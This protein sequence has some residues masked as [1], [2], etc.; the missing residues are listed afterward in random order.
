[1]VRLMAPVAL[2]VTEPTVDTVGID[3]LGR[4]TELD[5]IGSVAS[6]LAQLN[7]SDAGGIY[8][9]LTGRRR[10][11]ARALPRETATHRI[12]KTKFPR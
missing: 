2:V 12:A 8:G 9:H 5:S 4:R 7:R 11:T 3:L 10:R 1:M 6:G